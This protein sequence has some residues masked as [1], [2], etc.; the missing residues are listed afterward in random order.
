MTVEAAQGFLLLCLVVNYGIFALVVP[1]VLVW[2]R[3][4]VQATQSVVSYVKGALRRHS[5]CVHG[6]VQTWD[7]S[8]SIWPHTLHFA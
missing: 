4:D 6:C 7:S 3:L 2:P 1:R 5:L 8:S